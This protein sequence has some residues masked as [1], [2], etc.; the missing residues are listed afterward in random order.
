VP[1]LW[2]DPPET[3]SVAL[4][5]VLIASIFVGILLAVSAAGFARARTLSSVLRLVG[6]GC[7]VVV[8][9]THVAEALRVFPRMRW[10]D[11]HSV[12]HYVDLTTAVLG[13]TLLLSSLVASRKRSLR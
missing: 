7:L 13:I 1:V 9:L 8:V 3:M 12:G 5:K 4:L 11:P 2:G 10:G 6:A